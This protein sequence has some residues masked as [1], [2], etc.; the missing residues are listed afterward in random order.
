M[1]E[2]EGWD[3]IGMGLGEKDTRTAIMPQL[4]ELEV[5]GCT[6]LKAL[7]D[8]VLTAPL[9]EL[10]MNECPLL[11]ERYEEEKGEDWHKISH[12]S[13]IEINYQRSKRPP[14]KS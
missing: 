2:L 13:E 1:E 9:V 5:K 14:R 7:P 11:S 3:G 12:I 6:K 8:Y 4:R 10:R